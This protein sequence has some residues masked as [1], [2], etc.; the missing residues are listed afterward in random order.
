M[1]EAAA[2]WEDGGGASGL[3]SHDGMGL[4]DVSVVHSYTES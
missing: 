4:A 3:A 1:E 2:A